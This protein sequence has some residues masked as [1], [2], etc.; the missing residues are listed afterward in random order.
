MKNKI[1]LNILVVYFLILSIVLVIQLSST[2]T[3]AI[4]PLPSEITAED[5]LKNSVVLAINSP[6]VIVNEKQYLIDEKD[7]TLVPTIDNGKV[8]I[9]TKLL[10]TAFG[11]NINF[12]KQSKETIIRLD[13]KAIIFVN[14]GTSINII[15]N[16]SEETINIDEEAK[17]INDRFYI[18]LRSFADIFDK[19]VF[20]N[21]DLIIISSIEN[22]FDPIEE[23]DIL[24]ELEK[25][26]KQLP[27][28][29]NS[30]NLRHLLRR[31]VNNTNK[32][33]KSNLMNIET[34]DVFLQQKKPV[35]IKKTNNYNIYATEGFI[36]VY[37][38]NKD[39]EEIFSFKVE[40]V[41][42]NIKDIQITND[43]FIISYLDNIVKTFIY[44]ISNR[45]NIK[46]MEVVYNNGDFYKNIIDDNNLYI[47]SK[48]D[49]S[50]DKEKLP[51]FPE[52]SYKDNIVTGFKEQTFSLDNIFYFPD[53]NDNQYTIISYVN[54]YEL[55]E[56]LCNGAYLGM[57]NNIVINDDIIYVLTSN[58]E[59][60]NLYQF[61][62]TLDGI[63]YMRRV[64]IKGNVKS[65]EMDKE[66]QFL[67]LSLEDEVIYYDNNLT[68][69]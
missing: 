17:I 46:T 56:T 20:Y 37:F 18:P 8:Y 38:V 16:T 50:K 36:E 43:R 53:M 60:N 67:K 9:P 13:N 32:I 25:Q 19:E 58:S 2:K 33:T 15:D 69:R 5:K 24:E 22:L 3:N 59:N 55:D 39:K 14:N 28:V 42:N 48:I 23:M 64:F 21:N 54:L 27:I 35:I 30:D 68:K 65:L 63:Q 4:E 62:A 7:S 29:G 10:E 51:Y 34:L 41:N 47:V 26:V 6:V 12:S 57:G 61:K 40:K 45:E 31:E 52:Y 49:I 1:I 11:A 66:K 44:D